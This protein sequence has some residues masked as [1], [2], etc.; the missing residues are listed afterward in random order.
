MID[1][2]SPR[3][4]AL[5]SVCEKNNWTLKTFMLST[6]HVFSIVTPLPDGET[7]ACTFTSAERDL[8]VAHLKVLGF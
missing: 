6:N 4:R 3:G 2:N 8:I 5:L 1:E 7:H